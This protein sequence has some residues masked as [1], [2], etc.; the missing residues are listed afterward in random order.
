VKQTQSSKIQ[1]QI[2]I[3]DAAGR[4]LQGDKSFEAGS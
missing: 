3:R 2:Q 1:V 4:V